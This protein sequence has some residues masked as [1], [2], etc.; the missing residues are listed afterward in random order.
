MKLRKGDTVKVIA[1]KDKGKQGE[2]EQVLAQGQRVVVSGV[3]VVTRHVKPSSQVRQ[4]GR[5]ESEAPIH[6][7][8]VL[9]VC[10]ACSK[11]VKVGISFLTDGKKIR[12]CKQCKETMN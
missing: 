11:P 4:T 6:R 3:N 9:V 1:G 5:V 10:S 12:V 2:V 7:S 8:N